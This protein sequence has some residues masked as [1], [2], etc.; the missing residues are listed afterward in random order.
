MGT[1]GRTARAALALVASLGLALPAA[2]QTAADGPRRFTEDMARRFQ[3]AL[4]GS[5]PVTVRSELTLQ[6]GGEADAAQINLDRVWRACSMQPGSCA[7][8]ADD[9]VEGLVATLR[10]RH[11]P[12]QA[13]QL[14]LVVRSDD[15]VRHMNSSPPGRP[16]DRKR[17]FLARPLAP[18]LWTVGVLD[19]PRSTRAV[20]DGDLAALKLGEDEAFEAALKNV[21]GEYPRLDAGANVPIGRIGHYTGSYYESSR[22]IDHAAWAGLAARM[23][24]GL[25]VA[26]P[27]HDL[28][29]YGPGGTREAVDAMKTLARE[30]AGR[31][32]RPL[33]DRVYRWTPE[34]WKE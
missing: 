13:S 24:G 12:P 25:L 1:A 30:L 33:S 22:L 6:L 15:Y 31:A 34:G 20:H 7:K 32:Q 14:R 9:F 21:T 16:A 8:E 18:G 2:A 4:G 10:E 5:Q 26:V 19:L 27:S 28:V 11:Q 29:L 3:R 23:D 17:K